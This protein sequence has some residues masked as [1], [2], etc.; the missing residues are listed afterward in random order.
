MSQTR[1][2]TQT[3]WAGMSQVEGVGGWGLQMGEWANGAPVNEQ[4]M[5]LVRIGVVPW[6]RRGIEEQRG[7]LRGAE[8]RHLWY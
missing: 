2:E 6:G 8:G 4:G 5:T 1:G 3:V 7:L